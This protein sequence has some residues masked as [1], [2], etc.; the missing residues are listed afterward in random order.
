MKEIK[1]ALLAIATLT[2]LVTIAGCSSTKVASAKASDTSSAKPG[3]EK[4]SEKSTASNGS[5]N[6]P[7]AVTGEIAGS[8][9]FIKGRTVEIWAKWCCD[10]EVTQAEYQ[11]IM[12]ENPSK[13]SGSNKPV[14]N[15]SW[16]DAIMYCNKKS[17]A[18]GRTPCYKVDGK[19]DTKQWG[20]TPHKSN[21]ISGTITCNFNADGY[22]LPTEAE[23]EY[24]ARGGNTSNSGQTEYSGSNTI[25]SVAWYDGNSGNKTHEV[26]KKTANSLGLYDMSG[27]VW[28]WC[29]DWCGSINQSTDSTGAASGS[30]RIVRGGGWGDYASYCTVSRRIYSN[31]F[32]RDYDCG[33]RVVCSRSE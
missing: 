10:H 23:W 13:F 18:A 21:D 22:R 8:Q 3:E 30:F 27:N 9:V 4:E 2:L 5:A 15:V 19:T 7:L 24:F 16:Y 20:Y 12:G 11:S 17:V 28:E 31:P 6:K 32:Y 26:K 1:M 33:F 29:W 25:G 14:E